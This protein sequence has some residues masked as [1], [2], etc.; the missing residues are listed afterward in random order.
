MRK[1]AGAGM[2]GAGWYLLYRKDKQSGPREENTHVHP[3]TGHANWFSEHL[4]HSVDGLM[5]DLGG[6]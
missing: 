3:H 4:P 2:D 5:V 1:N 6:W